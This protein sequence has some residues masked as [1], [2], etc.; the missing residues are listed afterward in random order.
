MSA[1]AEYGA[2][3]S[4][5]TR[6]MTSMALVGNRV[7]CIFFGIAGVLDAINTAQQDG[8]TVENVAMYTV[9]A[10]LWALECGAKG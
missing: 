6:S 8:F 3:A 4:I 10:G 9:E 2:T 7:S 5:A 1:S